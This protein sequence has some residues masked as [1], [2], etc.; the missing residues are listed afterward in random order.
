TLNVIDG[1][2]RVGMA[3]KFRI[4]IARMV[5]RLQREPEVVH[6]K[7]VFEEFR[8]LEVANAASL[9]RGIEL[10]CSRIRASVEV[11]IVQRLID[12]HAPKNDRGM[13]PV[14]PDHAA[15]V[16]DRDPFPCLVANMLPAGNLLKHQQAELIA[17]V[18][19]VLRLRVMGGTHDVAV[20]LVSQ[21][22]SIA[23][24]P[25]A[26]HRL[27]DEGEG[28]MAIQTAPLDDLAI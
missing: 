5:G 10:V 21:N 16:V 15:D 6:R 12:A 4:Q 9:S 26:R 13:I 28:L 8:L 17:S 3:Y 27:A 14:A 11:V 2:R 19:E 20:Q 18:Q 1:F 24:L 25:T 7:H 22:V 23:T